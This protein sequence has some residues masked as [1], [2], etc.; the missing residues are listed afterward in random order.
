[1]NILLIHELRQ[2][3]NDVTFGAVPY[4]RM[5]KPHQVL[6][7]GY[8]EFDYI[9]STTVHVDPLIL[10]QTDLVIFTRIANQED[11]DFLEQMDIKW[12]VDVDDFWELPKNHLLYNSYK[13]HGTTEKIKNA[14]TKAQFVICTTEILAD[15]ISGL[16]KNVHIIENGIDSREWVSNKIRSNRVRFGFTQG[17]T[18]VDDIKLIS[19]SV[20]QSLKDDNFY[21]NG[22][23]VLC[24][25]NAK[26]NEP[27][28]YV[29]YEKMLT[30]SLNTLRSL[31]SDY[32]KRLIKVK[33]PNGVSKPY[34]RISAVNVESFY[35]I[36]NELDLVVAPLEA[37]EFNS[38]K[39]NI[40]MLEAGFMDC[41]VMVHN[42]S[43]YKE[44]I[45][46]ENCFDLSERSFF[47]W[48]KHILNNP[49]DLEDRK[50]ALKETVK[51]F[52]LRNL[53]DKRKE[54]YLK[55]KTK[56]K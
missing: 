5:Q 39:S 31:D 10:K 46:K 12:G 53:T 25:F 28:I 56:N 23:I 16:N 17:T 27:S 7:R 37:N 49:N 51:R 15:K 42:V 55:Y 3:G 18:H 48:Q 38:C 35:K 22:Q 30:D 11:I 8:P 36:H 32:V 4:Y 29:G 13:E 9:T 44:I 2:I 19:D 33:N 40:K 43:P 34:R 21:K 24:G 45:T 1:M 50:L 6:S 54:L 52:E 26:F 47:D 20:T 41:A 14:I